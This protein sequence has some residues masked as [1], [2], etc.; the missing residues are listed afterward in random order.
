MVSTKL[1]PLLLLL[2]LLLLFPLAPAADAAPLFFSGSNISGTPSPSSSDAPTGGDVGDVVCAYNANASRTY[3][4]SDADSCCECFHSTC[5]LVQAN[6]PLGTGGTSLF[7]YF[8]LQYCTLGEVQPISYVLLCIVTLV[9]FSLLGTT[10]D[11]FFVVQ[12]CKN[13]NPMSSAYP[14]QW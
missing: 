10:A 5:D 12:R 11:N 14:R 8:S 7:N 2:L 9:V 13:V 4:A 3:N 6:C 1:P